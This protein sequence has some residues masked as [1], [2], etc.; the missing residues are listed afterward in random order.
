M[1]EGKNTF[2]YIVTLLADFF[3]KK[4]IKNGFIIK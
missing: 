4:K 2:G 3:F 1:D